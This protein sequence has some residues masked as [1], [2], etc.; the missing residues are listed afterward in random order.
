MRVRVDIGIGTQ[1]NWCAHPASAGRTRD[2]ID[3]LQLRF[4]LDVETVNTLLERVFDFFARFPDAR[5]SA[6][7]RI[8]ARREHA[9]KFAAG[10]DVESCAF[11][12]EQLQ[13]RAVRVRLDC[14][15]NQMIERGERSIETAIMIENRACTVNIE[16][17]PELLSNARKIDSFA[18]EMPVAI[19]KKM[20]TR[21]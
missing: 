21:M 5:E 19:M 20:H 8:A 1:G 13:D 16:W 4:A 3:V 12:D 11:F 14:V 9:I 2:L 18:V 6:L 17:R 7:C 15:T 10:Y